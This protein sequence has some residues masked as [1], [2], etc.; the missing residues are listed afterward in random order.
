MSF[1]DNLTS[2]ENEKDPTD[3]RTMQ[4]L[5]KKRGETK[6]ELGLILYVYLVDYY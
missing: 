5:L 1:V 6:W 4:C 2:L 3:V